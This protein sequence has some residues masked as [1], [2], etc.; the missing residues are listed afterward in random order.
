MLTQLEI[1]EKVRSDGDSGI[2]LT[3]LREQGGLISD[4]FVITIERFVILI[5][6]GSLGFTINLRT[7]SQKENYFNGFII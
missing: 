7:T 1:E 3:R 6:Y 2:K 4:R 5:I